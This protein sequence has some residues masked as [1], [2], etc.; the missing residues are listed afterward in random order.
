[1]RV[2]LIAPVPPFRGGVSKYCYSLAKELEKKHE[3]LLLS[4]KRQY[5]ILLFGKKSQTDPAIDRDH[6]IN[7][8]KHLTYDIDSASIVSW[9][10]T[11]KKIA[12]FNPDIVVL[13]WFVVYWAP[14]YLYL[15]R[16]L[17]KQGIKVVMSCINVFEHEDNFIKRFLS[18]LVL[19]SVDSLI[20]HSEREKDEILEFHPKAKVIKHLLPLFEYGPHIKTSCDHKLNLLFFGCVRPYKG[21]DTLLNAIGILKDQDIALKIAGDFWYD[22]DRYLKLIEDLAISP[23][24]EIVDRYIPNDELS[25]FFSWADLVV[26]PYKKTKTSGII[27]TAYGFGKPV[28]TTNVGGFYEVVK[29]GYTG[30]IVAADDPEAFADGIVWFINHRETTFE[31][32]ILEFTSNNMS[33]DSLVRLIEEFASA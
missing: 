28:L 22:K 19:R 26:L 33:W 18:K 10:E 9:F 20:V 6:I 1:M 8:F 25:F 16:S 24:V 7:E 27:A 15:L 12:A 21:L 30:K 23:K 5:P 3:L 14:M 17:K 29:D 11:S 4:Y 13:P 31:E 32:N 2:C